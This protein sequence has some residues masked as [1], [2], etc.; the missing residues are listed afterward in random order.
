MI[1][2]VSDP[3]RVDYWTRY[4]GYKSLEELKNSKAWEG[5]SEREKKL[6]EEAPARAKAIRKK[7]EREQERK[8]A[9][10]QFQLKEKVPA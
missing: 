3:R 8:L 10:K 1:G 6:A 2:F 5:F 7:L 9:L 4:D